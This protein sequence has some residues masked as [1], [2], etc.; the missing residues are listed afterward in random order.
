MLSPELGE[1]VFA[2]LNGSVGLAE[3]EQ[4]LAPREARYLADLDG[5]DA[6]MVSAIELALAEY[7]DGLH[8]REGIQESIRNAWASIGFSIRVEVEAD[9]HG[10]AND[11]QRVEVNTVPITGTAALVGQV[12]VPG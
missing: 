9:A 10:S 1:K 4:W 6:K 3:L 8:T 5:D 11:T 7:Q 12:D 2:Y